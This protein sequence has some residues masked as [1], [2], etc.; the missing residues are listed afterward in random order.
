MVLSPGKAKPTVRSANGAATMAE[1]GVRGFDARQASQG[2][3]SDGGR[4]Y[5]WLQ[6]K[7]LAFFGSLGFR[8]GLSNAVTPPTMPSIRIALL[9]LSLGAASCATT[10]SETLLTPPPLGPLESKTYLDC[11]KKANG[12]LEQGHCMQD[13][14]KWQQHQMNLLI[15]RLSAPLNDAQRAQLTASQKTWEAFQEAE[16]RFAVSLYDPLGG[17]SDLIVST[18]RIKWIAQRRQQLHHHLDR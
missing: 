10:A 3:P 18:N 7:V 16:S 11:M 4:S 14:I 9:A 15:E 17:S 13:E 8:Q 6:T 2:S 5:K 1:P 12:R